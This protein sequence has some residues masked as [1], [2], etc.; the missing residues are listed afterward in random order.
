MSVLS[1]LEI[2][3]PFFELPKFPRFSIAQ[4]CIVPLNMHSKMSRA[5]LHI[6]HMILFN[7]GKVRRLV[8]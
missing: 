5:L 8:S 1:Q 4:A 7:N 2:E 6:I 3:I